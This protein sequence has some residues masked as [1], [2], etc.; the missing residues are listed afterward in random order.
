MFDSNGLK[1]RYVTEGAGEAVVLI[2][3]WMADSSMWGRDPSGNTRLN[4]KNTDGFRLIALDCRGHGQSDKPHDPAAYGPEMAADVVRLLDHLRIEKA[5]LV[6]YSSGAFIAGWVAANHPGRVLS[7]VYAGQA[8]LVAG[9]NATGTSEV[10]I[11][12]KLV[13]EG[14]DLGTYII[15]VTPPGWPKPTVDQAK[16]MAKFRFDGKDVLA[17][18]LAGRGFKALEVTAE[19]LKECPAPVLF[20]HGGNESAYVKDRVAAVRALLGR[21]EVRIIEGGDHMTTLIKPEFGSA[22]MTFLR[23]G[24][25]P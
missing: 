4:T 21:G 7:V 14:G 24:K 17:F 19:R 20:I 25:L 12:A 8:P 5:H 11:F 10:D 3:G 2:H 13:D 18:A 9:A 1:I 6:G 16:A 15:A 22:I 23:S